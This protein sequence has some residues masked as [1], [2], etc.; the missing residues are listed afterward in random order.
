MG[1]S[2]LSGMQSAF[3]STRSIWVCAKLNRF[4]SELHYI[5]DVVLSSKTTLNPIKSRT[6]KPIARY[7]MKIQKYFLPGLRV[8]ST[9]VLNKKGI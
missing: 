5:G 7:I 9:F 3:L 1:F 4:L 2:G 6:K 8:F